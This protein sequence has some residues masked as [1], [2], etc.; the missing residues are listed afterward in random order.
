MAMMKMMKMIFFA[1]DD[2]EDDNVAEDE[3]EEDDVVEDEVDDDDD[4]GDDHDYVADDVEDDDDVEE[5]LRRMGVKAIMQKM[6]W[7]MI[8]SKVMM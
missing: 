1:H 8:R 5:M 4:D 3:V 2:V 7:R 6:K